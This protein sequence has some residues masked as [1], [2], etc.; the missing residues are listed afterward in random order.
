MGDGQINILLAE[1]HLLVRGGIKAI[2]EREADFIISGEA[3]NGQLAV[4]LMT[5]GI[6]VD[7]IL[8]DMN[9]PV[10]AGI[11]LTE[12][13]TKHHPEV[14]VI[15]LSALDNDQYVFKA[16]KAG[17]SGYLLK[18]VSSSELIFAIRHTYEFGLYICAELS[19]RFLNRM[20]TVPAPVT[21]NNPIEIDFSN[22][23]VALLTLIADGY[24]NQ[25]IAAKQFT[26]VRTIENQR[27]HLLNK[28]SSKNT[29]VLI[30]FAML[31]GIIK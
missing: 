12:W 19:G 1:D 22:R 9:M 30:R 3:D 21:T 28:T 10:M 15:V 25:E 5:S 31:H 17:A 13:V 18:N 24:T 26:S 14:K 11:P 8:A 6:A 23:E 7:I 4:D 27:Q 2:L 16:I 29:V 20:L